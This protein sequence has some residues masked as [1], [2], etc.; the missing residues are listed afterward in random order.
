[1]ART[2]NGGVMPT[3]SYR[4]LSSK[5]R[6]CKGGTAGKAARGMRQKH[7]ARSKLQVERTNGIKCHQRSK[8]LMKIN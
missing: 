5:G 1:M 2:A 7:Y 3:G 4:N 6:A 8:V